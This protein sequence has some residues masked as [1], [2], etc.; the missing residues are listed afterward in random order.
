MRAQHLHANLPVRD[1]RRSRA[2][3]AAPG[4]ASDPGFTDD[5]AA[6]MTASRGHGD[7]VLAADGFFPTFIGK[8]VA[9]ART[10]AGVLA[11]PGPMYQSA[12]QAPDGRV[13]E[14]GCMEGMPPQERSPAA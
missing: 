10:S 12:L 4:F 1:R 13:A 2:F 11:G 9:D 7:V 14:L 8:R 6:C 3:F 5:E